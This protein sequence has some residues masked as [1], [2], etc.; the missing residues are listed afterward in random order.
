MADKQQ[1]NHH[2]YFHFH[3]VTLTGW[4]AD[5]HSF[6]MGNRDIISKKMP[7]SGVKG[8]NINKPNDGFLFI[9]YSAFV[10]VLVLT[11]SLAASRFVAVSTEGH[12]Y[13]I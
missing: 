9:I 10:Y 6:V 8:A 4:L 2:T 3:V 1:H 13:L 11:A 12:L 5:R 7:A